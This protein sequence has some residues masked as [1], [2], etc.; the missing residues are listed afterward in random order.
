MSQ[1]L[2]S[3]AVMIGALRV[4]CPM[5][6]PGILKPEITVKYIAVFIIFFNSGISLKSEVSTELFYLY[7]HY[8][9]GHVPWLYQFW[10]GGFMLFVVLMSRNSR[11][12]NRQWFWF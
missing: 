5:F 10:L 8:V 11:R 4:K 9:C 7:L 2:S 12:L 6:F 3:V 1:N